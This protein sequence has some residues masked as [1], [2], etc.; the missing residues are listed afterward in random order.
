M[1][2]QFRQRFD[3]DELIVVRHLIFD[4][5]QAYVLL[6]R[7]TVALIGRVTVYVGYGLL[8]VG[9]IS[10]LIIVNLHI[11]DVHFICLESDLLGLKHVHQRVQA[12]LP[13]VMPR[14]DY[15]P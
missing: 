6:V 2:R 11:R 8:L 12:F 3:I 7:H 1:K 9:V 10:R 15:L 5:D 4:V 14:I 13:A